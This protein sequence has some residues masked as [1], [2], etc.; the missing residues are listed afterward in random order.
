MSYVKI[1]TPPDKLFTNN[2]SFLLIYPDKIVKDDFQKIIL[3]F[4]EDF[5]IYLY[6]IE[7]PINHDLEWLLSSCYRADFVILDIDNCSKEIKELSSYIVANT[8]TY[9]L[10]QAG[11][12]V[13][14]ILSKNRIYTL[15]FLKQ[16]IGEHIEQK[17]SFKE[18]TSA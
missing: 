9:W 1:I 17:L 12:P 4:A 8:N 11:N 5:D 2:L 18:T 14:N 3:E 6:D 15:D 13:Y 10:T 7:N 16:K